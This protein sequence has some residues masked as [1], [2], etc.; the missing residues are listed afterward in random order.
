MPETYVLA[1]F[2]AAVAI[3]GGVVYCRRS[4][5]VQGSTGTAWS[6][7]VLAGL[8]Q[9]LALVALKARLVPINVYT[10][11]AILGFIIWCIIQTYRAYGD[12]R[13]MG[14]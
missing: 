14:V 3:A 13:R 4:A 9:L 6:A 8:G 10:F 7:V 2:F 5:V 12:L 1:V 11:A